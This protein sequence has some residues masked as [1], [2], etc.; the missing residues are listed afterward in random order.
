M[1][2]KEHEL[3]QL[4]EKMSQLVTDKK[5]KKGSEFGVGEVEG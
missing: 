2:K 1:K 3:V 4:K 5:D